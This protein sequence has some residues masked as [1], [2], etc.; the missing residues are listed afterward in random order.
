M[1]GSFEEGISVEGEF[2]LTRAGGGNFCKESARAERFKRKYKFNL[3]EQMEQRSKEGGGKGNGEMMKVLLIGGS[4]VGRIEEKMQKMGRGKVEKVSI[5]LKE[6]AEK[7]KKPDMVL[8]GGSDNCLMEHGKK[9][10][11]GYKPERKVA[12]RKDVVSGK[13]SHD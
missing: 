9:G 5:A 12:V 10:Q 3:K 8:V 2:S 7:G 13:L 4:Q 1:R 11:R 6:Q